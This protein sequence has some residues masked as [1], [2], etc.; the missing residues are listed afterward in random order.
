MGAQVVPPRKNSI[1]EKFG[2]EDGRNGG[3]QVERLLLSDVG[4]CGNSHMMMMENNSDQ[5]AEVLLEW[6]NENALK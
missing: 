1:L 5:I 3:G 6:I 2:K 4:I